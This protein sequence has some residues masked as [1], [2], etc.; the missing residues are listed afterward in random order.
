MFGT[1]TWKKLTLPQRLLLWSLAEKSHWVAPEYAP[2]KKLIEL[3]LIEQTMMYP[4]SPWR[5][6]PEGWCTLQPWLWQVPR[7]WAFRAHK[8]DR[9]C[10]VEATDL[11]GARTE[12]HAGTFAVALEELGLTIP[13]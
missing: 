12:C 9:A 13:K 5:L 6:T 4:S 7:G 2:R 1:D 8:E 3:G 11:S 10:F